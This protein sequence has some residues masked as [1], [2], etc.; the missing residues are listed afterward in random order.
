M[1][2]PEIA[3]RIAARRAELGEVEERLVKQLEEVRAERD[4]LAVA[5]RVWRRM[6]EQIT[7]EHRVVAPV[8][9]QVGGR[10][11]LLVPHREAGMEETALP[12][13]YQRI[14]AVVR[15]AGGAVTARQVAEGLGLETSERGKLEPLRGKLTRLADRGWLRKL[16]GGQFTSRL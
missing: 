3:E 15:Q 8:S 7:E 9:V 1:T 11:V 14:L 5:E 13:E 16:P 12:P 2:D 10:G 4:E 6:H